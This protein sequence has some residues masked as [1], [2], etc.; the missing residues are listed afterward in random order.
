MD[1]QLS[2]REREAGYFIHDLD[3]FR[4]EIIEDL[5]EVCGPG[6]KVEARDVTKNNG[7]TLHGITL[8]ESGSN[9]FPNIY[10]ESFYEDYKRGSI[11]VKEVS[12]E[13]LKA[14]SK[15]KGARSADM[16]FLTDFEKVKGKLIFRLINAEKNDDLLRDI[17]H[18]RFLDLAVTYAVHI[19]DIFPT[20]GNVMVGKDL[21]E[22]WGTDEEEL[23]RLALNNTPRIKQPVI[24]ELSE[25]LGDLVSDSC[26]MD[27]G[28]K[29]PAGGIRM[30]VLTNIDGY[31]GDSIILYP[32]LLKEVRKT[33]DKDFFLLPSSVHEFIMVP[34]T[35]DIKE[36]ELAELVR[37]V[38]Q[39]SV[40]AEDFLSDNVYLFKDDTVEI[41]R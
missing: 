33:V 25:M 37:S 2:F 40:G 15:E 17:P 21:M 38:N 8:A 12:N 6:F 3:E 10:L 41:C 4:S 22:K 28:D 31:Y 1:I 24:K 32:G 34:D 13:I 26:G 39:S 9:I 18:R 11:N 36:D 19:D 27:S 29:I 35:G 23:Y 7:V 14:Y 20:S 30:F 5:N 16:C